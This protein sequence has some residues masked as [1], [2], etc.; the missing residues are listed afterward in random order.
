MVKRNKSLDT[1]KKLCNK[2][3]IGLKSHVKSMHASTNPDRKI[4]DKSQG[5]LQFNYRDKSTIKKL[6]NLKRSNPDY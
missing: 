6:L 2:F 5:A 1:K 4:P 3:K